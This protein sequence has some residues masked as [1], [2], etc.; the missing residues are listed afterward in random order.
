MESPIQPFNTQPTNSIEKE[1]REPKVEHLLFNGNKD[2]LI[3]TSFPWRDSTASTYILIQAP[4]SRTYDEVHRDAVEY[5]PEGMSDEDERI[6]KK[7]F[8]EGNSPWVFKGLEQAQKWFNESG[9]NYDKVER[10]RIAD[11]L[12]IE[13]NQD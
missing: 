12:G 9:Y 13:D 2:V 1:R 4:N 10:K 11:F 8:D 5:Y 3:K 7:V 6:L